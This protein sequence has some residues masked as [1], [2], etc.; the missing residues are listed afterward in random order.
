MEQDGLKIWE[1]GRAEPR[2]GE[3]LV[4][5]FIDS[6]LLSNES[7]QHSREWTG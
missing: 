3:D 6:T 5:S 4:K 2:S 7:F 1:P